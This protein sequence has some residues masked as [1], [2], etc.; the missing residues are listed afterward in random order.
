MPLLLDH[1]LIAVHTLPAAMDNFA[2][3][4]FRVRRGRTDAA[5]ERA[6]MAF[7]DGTRLELV[8]W[9]APA[10]DDARWRRLQ[11]Y[12]E[13]IVDYGLATRPVDASTADVHGNG[14]VGVESLA[15]AVHDVDAE[16]AR[17]RS[18]AGAG[19]IGVHLGAALTLPVAGTRLATVQLASS[20][21]LLMAPRAGGPLAQQEHPLAL[22]L[23]AWGE[24][25]YALVLRTQG[26]PA[27]TADLR[28]AHGASLEFAPGMAQPV[29]TSA[30]V[31]MVGG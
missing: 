22:R 6:S 18:L 4:G 17:L 10:T 27:W 15:I 8:A 11:Q 20:A 12:G 16:R 9:T 30:S 28:L 23:A 14:A 5:S 29:A 3:L 25:P 7:G 31:A 13:G 26:G 21:L 19:D 1:V 24:G 2:A